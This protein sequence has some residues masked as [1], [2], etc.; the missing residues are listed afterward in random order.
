[1][2][3]EFRYELKCSE[4][5]CEFKRNCNTKGS[6]S[7]ARSVFSHHMKDAHNKDIGFPATASFVKDNRQG[8]HHKDEDAVANGTT[9]MLE[10][11]VGAVIDN[12]MPKKLIPTAAGEAKLIPKAGGNIM[13]GDEKQL[14]KQPR[15]VQVIAEKELDE[16]H[17]M[18]LEALKND[19]E[20]LDK[21]ATKVADKIK[22][23]FKTLQEVA[24]VQKKHE[25]F[26]AMIDDI[27]T[28]EE[29]SEPADDNDEEEE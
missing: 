22:P 18:Q 23:E 24:E 28:E 6:L 10:K 25:S 8:H 19:E 15:K 7:S 12:K 4:D 26:A 11:Q 21:I 3:K 1:M 13:S 20:F 2:G 29:L 16:E 9:P 27:E 5:G 14:K 17:D